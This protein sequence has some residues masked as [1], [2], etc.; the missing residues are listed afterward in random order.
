MN[1]VVA[2]ALVGAVAWGFWAFF[3]DLA[4]RSMEPEA[5][6][7]VSYS[8]GI[9]LAAVYIVA[10]GTEV[11]A[12]DPTAIGF[13]AAAGIASGIGA[14]AYY[15]ALQAGATGVAT[16]V[17]G[18]YFVIAAV[19]GVVFLGDAMDATDVLGIGAAVVAILLLSY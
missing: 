19:L 4:T 16:A 9:V 8:V 2:L 3:A 17:T 7:V 15:A 10:R 13:A 18:L 5:A 14:I 1:H 6:M 12:S 11:L